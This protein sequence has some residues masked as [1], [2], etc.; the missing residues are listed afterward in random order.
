LFLDILANRKTVGSVSGN[1]T[2][3]GRRFSRQM[4]Q[5][6]SSYVTQVWGNQWAANPS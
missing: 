2:Y 5:S 3:N 6:V 4:V 1:V